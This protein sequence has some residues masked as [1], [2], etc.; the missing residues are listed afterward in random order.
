M[1]NRY[2]AIMAQLG[3][4]EQG[5]PYADRMQQME[6]LP[7]HGRSGTIEP[8]TV[9]LYAQPEVKNPDGSTSTVDS[10]GIN[11]DGKEYLLPT[12]TPDGRHFVNEA[13]ARGVP[14]NQLGKAVGKMAFDE[15]RKTGLHLGVFADVA[16]SNAFADQLHNDYAAGKYRVRPMPSHKVRR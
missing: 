13:R 7:V 11:I 3:S 6:P 14:E 16:S 2:A 15:F 9:D 4:Q 10:I 8:G 12:V 1:A 5:S